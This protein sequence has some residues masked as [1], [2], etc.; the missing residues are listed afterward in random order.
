[1]GI[2]DKFKKKEISVKELY[3]K[4]NNDITDYNRNSVI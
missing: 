2:F 3:S 4:L 1:M